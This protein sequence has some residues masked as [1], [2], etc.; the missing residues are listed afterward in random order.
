MA[1]STTCCAM[2]GTATLI[3]LTSLETSLGEADQAH[4]MEHS[5][6][7]EAALS[8]LERA[9]GAPTRMLAAGTRTSLKV[10]SPCPNGSSRLPIVGRS[11]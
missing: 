7:V 3:W 9:P 2:I 6:R 8:Q 11:R 1:M 5:T 10:T 4:A